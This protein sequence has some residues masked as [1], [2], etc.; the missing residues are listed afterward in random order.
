MFGPKFLLQWIRKLF[1][2]LAPS[3]EKIDLTV[4]RGGREGN[5]IPFRLRAFARIN[6]SQQDFNPKDPL[7]AN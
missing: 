3:Q 2:S 4:H 1:F 6:K 5:A 7:R